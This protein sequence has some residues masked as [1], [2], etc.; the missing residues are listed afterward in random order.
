M[1]DS[2][3]YDLKLTHIES[4]EVIDRN[5]SGSMFDIILPKRG[6]WIAEYSYVDQ[7]GFRSNTQTINLNVNYLTF[8][9]NLTQTLNSKTFD[10]DVTNVQDE[11]GQQVVSYLVK[12]TH[13]SGSNFEFETNT[14]P[15]SVEFN[16]DGNW[17]VEV[18]ALDQSYIASGFQS[19]S[20]Y[21]EE[22]N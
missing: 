21:S 8:D 18:T 13:E 15:Y 16:I 10:L 1:N 20:V 4:G 22:P 9:V 6:N 2:Y 12:A 19:T 3:R 17:N 11:Y 7:F 5:D 14:V